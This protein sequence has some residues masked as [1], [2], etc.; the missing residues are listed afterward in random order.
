LNFSNALH[1]WITEVM[2]RSL[3]NLLRSLV[4]SKQKESKFAKKTKK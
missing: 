1:P 2:N 4:G 3:E